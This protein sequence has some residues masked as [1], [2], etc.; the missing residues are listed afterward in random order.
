MNT[1]TKKLDFYRNE[2]TMLWISKRIPRPRPYQPRDVVAV[3]VNEKKIVYGDCEINKNIDTAID[4]AI[5]ES[6]IFA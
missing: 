2:R 5:N 4:R 6:K 1:R 3:H